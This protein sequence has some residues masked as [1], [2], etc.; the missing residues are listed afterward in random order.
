MTTSSG[1]RSTQCRTKL[2]P[3]N[4]APPVTRSFMQSEGIGWLHPNGRGLVQRRRRTYFGRSGHVDLAVIADHQPG[5]PRPPLAAGD[6]D[7]AAQEGVLEPA[8]LGHRGVSQH[9]RVLDD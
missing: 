9:D 8:D 7:M 2:D 6:L 4:P 3:M 5:R 1:C